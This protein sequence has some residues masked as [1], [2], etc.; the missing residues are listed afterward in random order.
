MDA[1]R[2]KRIQ[3]L[4]HDA[5]AIPG[6]D[7]AAWLGTLCGDDPTLIPEVLALLETENSETLLDRDLGDVARGL[8]DSGESAG[9]PPAS[10]GP[11]RVV[12][13]LG[14]GGMGVVYLA[15]REDLRSRAAIKVL[16]DAW[17]SPA[18]RERFQAEQRTLARLNHPLI[19]RLYDAGTLADGTPWFV[20]EYVAGRPLNLH[21]REEEL[22]ISGRLSLFRSVCEAVQHAHR[23]AIIH[24]DLKPSNVLVTADGTVKLLD[25]GI[26]KELEEREEGGAPTRT[27]LRMMTPAYAA[28][29][30]V[31]GDPPGLHT[32]I[33][34]LGVILYELLSGRLPFDLADRTPGEADTIIL[35]Q[36]PP[37]PSTIRDLRE[38]AP[39]GRGRLDGGRGAWAD[40]DVLI[41]TAMH[42]DPGRRYA[43]VDALIRDLDRFQRNEPL[44]ARPDSFGYR[45]GKFARRNR[46]PLIV[47][48]AVVAAITSLTAW[49]TVQLMSARDAA[50]AESTRARRTQKFMTD[51][52]EGGDPAAGPA[53]SLR[54]V[55]LLD[56]GLLEAR[57]LDAEPEVQT[58][59]YATL[60]GIQRQMGKLDKADSLLGLALAGSRAVHGASDPETAERLVDLGLLRSDQSRF[61][62]ALSLVR[63]ALSAQ[64]KAR[65][66]DPAGMARTLSALG[67]VLQNN[68]DNA[69]AIDTLKEALR[70]HELAGSSPEERGETLTQLANSH[71]YTGDLAASDSLNRIVLELDRK[72]FG[73]HHPHVASDLLNL[74]AIQQEQGRNADAEPFYREA[75]GIYE[76]WYGPDHHE[77]A[78]TLTMI[79]RALIPQGRNAEAA[80]MLKRSLDIR[81]R[82]YGPESP[83]VASTLNEI[84][85]L[86]QAE[87]RLDEAIDCYS[88]MAAI[89]RIVYTGEHQLIGVALANL[90]GALT[91][92]GDYRA[93]EASF[94]DAIRM[95]AAT[96]PG[97]HLYVGIARTKLG[98]SLLR[99]GR[100]ADAER[101]SR[102]GYAILVRQVDP[103]SGWL[104]NARKD[105]VEECDR[106]N[107]H[108]DAARFRAE[109]EDSTIA[110]AAAGS[111]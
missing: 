28:P 93:A 17:V 49:Y 53:E 52:F 40:L 74:G 90:G 78:A 111:D 80:E 35:E 66:P 31:R 104:V 33:Y 2:W 50:L 7:R 57:R 39:S 62:E 34:A 8:F 99:A 87:G 65:P 12:R 29:E 73:D 18:R 84:G 32:D 16:K 54:V 44:E 86:A 92:R 4:F 98:R 20:M 5:A 46:T 103:L 19:A 21:A 109:L 91:E 82:I 48:G 45:A 9:S 72:I 14:E 36:S 56:R 41:L 100:I 71:F 60:G 108:E 81:M 13:I 6:A 37:R 106:L 69:A 107:R 94:R 24:R 59:L 51:L 97:D 68:G 101:E 105:L 79:A 43:S 3:Q 38:G 42:K 89:Y 88:R 61:D 26:A 58:D 25:F 77:T 95:Y 27:L 70:F 1:A 110:R 23:H 10:F 85:R 47:A 15:E 55:T 11:Y 64:R 102:A 96:L 67:L 63:Q 83:G 30:Q 75:L 22:S 76:S